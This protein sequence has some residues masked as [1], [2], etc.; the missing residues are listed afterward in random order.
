MNKQEIVNKISEQAQLPK[1][2][3]E[4]VI[5]CFFYQT[6]HAVKVGHDVKLKGFGTFKKTKVRT[7]KY[8]NPATGEFISIRAQWKPKV[9]FSEKLRKWFNT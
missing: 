6:V 2:T 4:A 3:V 7:R 9:V 5:D 8:R 1:Q